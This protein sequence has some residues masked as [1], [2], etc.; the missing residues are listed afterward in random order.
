[1][2]LLA[3]FFV[4]GFREAPLLA[5]TTLVVIGFHSVIS[6][7]EL[8]FIYAALPPAMITVGLGTAA[9][10]QRLPS[11]LR[12]P[13]A[14]TAC[15]G[16]GVSSWLAIASP[17]RICRATVYCQGPYPAAIAE[18]SGPTSAPPTICAGSPSTQRRRFPW[19]WSEGY[20]GLNKAVP[21]YLPQ[22]AG[23]AGAGRAWRKLRHRG[24]GGFP[25]PP[26]LQAD[27]LLLGDLPACI[28]PARAHSF[29]SRKFQGARANGAIPLARRVPG[30]WGR[31]AVRS[32]GAG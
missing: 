2:L 17:D 22:L 3:V 10:V 15:C 18:A 23:G 19:V 4:L 6:H 13:V 21:M 29:R 27:S 5:L 8:S 24:R 16:R 25:R 1:M 20:T 30:R 26:G 32:Y 12:G 31:A 14:R 28:A 9:A 7:K 11:M